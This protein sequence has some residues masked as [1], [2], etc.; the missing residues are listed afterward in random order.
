VAATD[1]GSQLVDPRWLIEVEGLAIL[2][3]RG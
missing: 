1:E 2:P 3:P